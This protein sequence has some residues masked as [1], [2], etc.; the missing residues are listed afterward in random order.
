[1]AQKKAIR[2]EFA[3]FDEI[4][5]SID[6]ARKL[7]EEIL[8]NFAKANGGLRYCDAFEKSFSKALT[9]AKEVGVDIP[10]EVI[11]LQEMNNELRSFFTKIKSLD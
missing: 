10:Q 11:K 5:N 3:L 8:S 1:M 7:K 4:K 6:G 9:M 2:I